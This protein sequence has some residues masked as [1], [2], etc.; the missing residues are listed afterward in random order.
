MA[1]ETISGGSIF[2][3]STTEEF[4]RDVM[5]SQDIAAEI[6]ASLGESKA[7]EVAREI[8]GLLAPEPDDTLH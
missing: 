1:E 6:V 4:V 2:R 7:L 3:S 5:L 8:I